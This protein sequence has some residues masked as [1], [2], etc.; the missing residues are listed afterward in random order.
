MQSLWLL[1][2]I[3]SAES[4]YYITDQKLSVWVG[5][6]VCVCVLTRLVQTAACTCREVQIGL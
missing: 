3:S 6:R 1:F 2:A 5:D 4:S